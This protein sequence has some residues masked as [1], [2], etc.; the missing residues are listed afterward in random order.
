[1]AFPPGSLLMK[2]GALAVSLSLAI[3]SPS[4]LFMDFDLWTLMPHVVSPVRV[5]C[6]GGFPSALE[7][8]ELLLQ[9]FAFCL[10]F[11]FTWKSLPLCHRLLDFFCVGRRGSPTSSGRSRRSCQGRGHACGGSPQKVVLVLLELSASSFMRRRQP[12]TKTGTSASSRHSTGDQE[13]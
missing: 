4:A 13:R 6:F 11:T 5:L 9:A 1:M 10:C 7:P 3:L 8:M 2:A 12:W